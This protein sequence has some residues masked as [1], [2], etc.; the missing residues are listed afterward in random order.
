MNYGVTIEGFKKKR[1]I[2]IKT[3]I[4]ESLKLG[5]GDNISLIPQSVFGQLVGVMSERESIEWDNM[6][7]VYNAF[8]PST[9]Q[10][11]QLSE[12]VALNGIQRLEATRSKV[13]LTITG[14]DGTIINRGSLVSTVDSVEQFATDIDVVISDS[15]TVDATAV[16]T[17]AV[18]AIAGS[19]TEIDTP[20]SG[21]D[22]VTNSADATE[23][24]DEETDIELRDRRTKSTL[25]LGNNLAD[26]LFG[27]L[28]NLD[29][30][31]SALVLSNGTDVTDEN[32]IPAHQFLLIV[33]GGLNSDIADIVWLNTPQGIL[34]HGT[35]TEQIIDSQGFPQDVKFSRPTTV[36]IYFKVTV[37]TDSTYP[38][39]GDLD[40][41]D[42]IIE[43]SEH[44]GI[45]EDVVLSQFYTPINEVQGVVSIDLRIGLTAS[46]TGT[47]NL[48]IAFDEISNYDVSFIE[49]ISS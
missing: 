47:T 21:W 41:K 13:T 16:N 19:L 22:T 45:G 42:N 23:G 39:S 2:D 14:V 25:A 10:G 38:G 17:G 18:L 11:V 1:L 9:A 44:Y 26:S 20:I 33:E 43:Y 3:E 29:N 46:L 6:E 49:V 24:T 36:D 15:T 4:E 8:Y 40:I 48:P 34:S 12:L 37:T 30:V 28:S 27:Q 32:G 35:I 5:F 7:N 31:T